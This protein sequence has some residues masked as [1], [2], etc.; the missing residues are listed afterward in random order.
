LDL[1]ITWMEQQEECSCFR[2]KKFMT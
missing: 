2:W 1:V